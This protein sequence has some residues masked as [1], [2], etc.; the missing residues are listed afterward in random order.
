MRRTVVIDIRRHNAVL[1][2]HERYF[3]LQS[4]G[5]LQ[6]VHD[7]CPH[8]GGPLSLARL[9]PDGRRLTCPW[10][11]TK[12]AV[13]AVKRTALPMVLTGDEATIIL[14]DLPEDVPVTPIRR[15]ILAN[16]PPVD[17]M[18]ELSA[19]WCPPGVPNV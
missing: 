13:A 19:P 18:A 12:V 16:L 9:T 14:P 5:Q 6:L 15:R 8:R 4:D 3:M 11:G 17:P 1:V 10:H 7:K 2:G